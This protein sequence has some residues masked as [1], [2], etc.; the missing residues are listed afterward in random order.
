MRC[1]LIIPF[2]FTFLN[3]NQAQSK[4]ELEQKR[5]AIQNEIKLISN[6]LKQTRQSQKEALDNY[7]ILQRQIQKRNQLIKTLK[8]EDDILEDRITRTSDVLAS[9]EV[10]A[11]NLEAEYGVILRQAL[12]QKL[13]DSYISFLFSSKDFNEALS[14]WN[15]LNQY[16]AYRSR[17]ATIIKET[18]Q[19][20]ARKRESLQNLSKEKES[21]LAEQ[22]KQ[23]EQLELESQKRNKMYQSLK[24][25]EKSLRAELATQQEDAFQLKSAILSLIN[26]TPIN[27]SKLNSGNLT[28]DFQRGKGNLSWPMTDGLVIRFFGKQQHPTLPQIEIVNNG[29]D[30]QS[31]NSLAVTA[32]FSGEVAGKFTLPNGKQSIL[33]KHGEYYTVY[34]NLEQIYVQQGDPIS[35]NQEIGQLGPI[36]RNLHFE[37]WRQKVRLNPIDWL[38]RK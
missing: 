37:I 1:L 38:S 10:D 24:S 2:L 18:Q 12:R 6:R 3:F 31:D 35:T 30:I 8:K 20:L 26:N 25:D 27:T 19:S 9:L 22:L 32:A 15:Y 34:S 16:R 21:L 23:Q 17:Q 33:L 28:T 4:L 36:E 14:R 5:S 29:I 7:L 11:V 13:S